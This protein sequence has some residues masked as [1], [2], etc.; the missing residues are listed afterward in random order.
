MGVPPTYYKCSYMEGT[1]IYGK[2]YSHLWKSLL[3][4]NDKHHCILPKNNTVLYL[5]G[6]ISR[7]I[8]RQTRN[9]C[10]QP[11]Q[12]FSSRAWGSCHRQP[13][14]WNR[15]GLGGHRFEFYSGES[16]TI[17]TFAIILSIFLESNVEGWLHGCVCDC[18]VV[19]RTVFSS[20][21]YHLYL[22]LPPAH[23]FQIVTDSHQRCTCKPN[24]SQWSKTNLHTRLG[25]KVNQNNT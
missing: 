13:R 10:N 12:D 7:F 19:P 2:I 22:I 21:S 17:L 11:K 24:G 18:R 14:I 8:P 4:N 9:Y 23:G 1:P 15:M 25:T 16:G 20:C 3:W 5:G 6:I